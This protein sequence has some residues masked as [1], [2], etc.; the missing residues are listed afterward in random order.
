MKLELIPEAGKFYK[1]NMHCHTNISDGKG[2]P[3]EI[4]EFYKAA[5]YSAVCYTDHE[6]LIGHKDLCDD[7][8]IA[9]HGYEVAIKKD[10]N[11]HTAYFM[12]VYHFNMIAK[13]QNNLKM[14]RYFKENP[15]CP[16]NSKKWMDECAVYDPDDVIDN[17]YYDPEWINDYLEGVEKGGFFINYN[18]P[19][20]SLQTSGDYLPLK[21]L[22]SVE[23]I[24]GGCLGVGD[25]TGIHYGE[26]LRAKN[27]VVPTGG[28]D[29]HNANGRLRAFTMI[30]AKELTYEALIEAYGKGDCYASEGPELLGLCIEDGK[31]VVRCSPCAGVYILSEGRYSPYKLSRT[32]LYTE[33]R[34]D[35]LPEKFGRFFR[36]ELRD[37]QGYRAMSNAY[38]TE[39][40]AQKIAAE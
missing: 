8:F 40:I 16:G 6:V 17:V 35:Y 12:P 3:E 32:E 26:F 27:R 11:K 23:L 24:N 15:S 4:K 2:S 25:N 1:V 33:V 9:L 37:A 39:E 31:I 38:Y 19:Q 34:F 28:D 5:G 29:N 20:W 18:H 7:E 36:V 22:H 10:M 30:K 13:D 21:H 14:P